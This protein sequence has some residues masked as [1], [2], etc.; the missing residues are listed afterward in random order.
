[1]KFKNRLEAA[2][3]LIPRLMKYKGQNPLVLGIPRGAMPM[4]RMIAEDLQ[5]ELGAVLV[6]KIPH[7][8]NE[9]LAV[10]SIA[11]SGRIHKIATFRELEIPKNYLAEEAER[12]LARL[13]ARQ[14]Q[15]H[16]GD[17]N[18]KNR[19]V[20]LVDDGIAT[21]AT[22]LGAIDEVRAQQ[23]ARLVLAAGVCAP[24]TAAR[25]R[26]LVDE[27]VVLDIPPFFLAVGE[28]FDDFSEVTDKDVIRILKQDRSR[29]ELTT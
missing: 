28:F 1:M 23:P 6:H 29:H 16:L 4:A 24:D 10:A 14:K 13:R 5:G 3:L 11:L 18:C 21:G 9:E 19:I 25:L 12:Q 7:P 26:P 15:F 17:L 20:I 27:F 2:Q 8:L 22:V